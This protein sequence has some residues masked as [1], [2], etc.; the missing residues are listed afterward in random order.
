[1]AYLLDYES[2]AQ[3]NTAVRLFVAEDSKT[4]GDQTC[5][6]FQFRL[7]P[8]TRSL[9]GMTFDLDS[10]AATRCKYREEAAP[11]RPDDAHNAVA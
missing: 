9:N 2:D 1:M 11:S 4:D 8:L 5:V 10:L 6:V 3:N 7:L